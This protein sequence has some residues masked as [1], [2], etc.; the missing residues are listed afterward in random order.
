MLERCSRDTFLLGVIKKE[1]ESRTL[2]ALHRTTPFSPSV[3][4][5]DTLG[6]TAFL[7]CS[8]APSRT[9]T[10]S[11]GCKFVVL[12]LKTREGWVAFHMRLS[13]GVS[14]QWPPSLRWKEGPLLRWEP[15]PPPW[16]G[17]RQT[18]GPSKLKKENIY[19]SLKKAS[20]WGQEV[21]SFMFLTFTSRFIS[22]FWYPSCS[23][24]IFRSPWPPQ[25]VLLAFF[26]GTACFPP[27]F[28]RLL[29]NNKITKILPSVF[30]GLKS[31]TFL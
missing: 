21:L 16:K 9:C 5:P 24:Y 31:L 10:V 15:T 30:V 26:F 4:I 17:R 11:N 23:T 3:V 2:V 22:G 29:D 1:T 20:V 14:V 28:C 12:W 25:I 13:W 27:F 19:T 18:W 8:P 7:I 6:P